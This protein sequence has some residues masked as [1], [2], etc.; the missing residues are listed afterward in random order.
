MVTEEKCTGE[1]E[2]LPYGNPVMGPV[3]VFFL[4]ITN[5]DGERNTEHV[6]EIHNRK[7]SVKPLLWAHSAFL[8]SPF[9]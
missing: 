9:F 1:K 7:L 5:E 4:D 2:R 8:L 3:A 6:R